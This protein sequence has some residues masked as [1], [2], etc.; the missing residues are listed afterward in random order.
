MLLWSQNNITVEIDYSDDINDF[1]M[2]KARRKP[3]LYQYNDRDSTKNKVKR[4]VKMS[5]MET[6]SPDITNGCDERSR[7]SPEI[8]GLDIIIRRCTELVNLPEIPTITKR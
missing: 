6:E 5:R 7:I 8:E 4:S 3:L 1:A 2:I